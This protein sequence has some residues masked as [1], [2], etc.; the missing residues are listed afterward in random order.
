MVT[1]MNDDEITRC[2][3]VALLCV[4]DRTHSQLTE[5]IPEKCGLTGQPKGLDALLK[6]VILQVT[7][8]MIIIQCSITKSTVL[9]HNLFI[10]VVHG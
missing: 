3:M 5:L 7:M 9:L 2:E 1:G 8:F 6:K 10:Y 4:S